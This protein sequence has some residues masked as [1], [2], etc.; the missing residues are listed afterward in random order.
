MTRMM[1]ALVSAV[2]ALL[3]GAGPALACGGLIG[4]NDTVN[5]VRTTTLAAYTDGV[6]HYVTSFSFVGAGAKFGSIVPLPGVPTDVKKAGRW[7]LQRLLQEVQPPTVAFAARAVAENGTADSAQVI[8]EAEVDA[9]DITVLKG[10]GDEVGKWATDNGFVLPPDA[11][12]VLDFYATRS[13][14]FMAVRFDADR[15]AERNLNTGDGIPIHLT[16]PTDDPWVPLRI[17]GLGKDARE[18]IE[19]D[20]F[21]LTPMRP[22]LL[23]REGST[24]DIKASAPASPALLSDLRADRGMGWLPRDDMWLSYLEIDAAA[25]ELTHDLAIDA[26]GARRPDPL[27]AGFGLPGLP[28]RP[29]D[30]RGFALWWIAVGAGAAAFVLVGIDR[31]V[32]GRR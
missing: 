26:S 19:A 21:L 16:I 32:V 13:P 25:G 18:R 7:T 4:A 8:L 24:Y 30:A 15:A 11:P 31:G 23:P 28:P 1:R 29:S 10:G 5:L 2:S 22:E 20:V 6:E 9:L 3:L 27:D 12:E 17:L 14:I